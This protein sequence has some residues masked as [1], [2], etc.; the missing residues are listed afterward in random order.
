MFDR[1]TNRFVTSAFL[2]VA[3][4]SSL[5]AQSLPASSDTDNPA[6]EAQVINPDPKPLQLP[7]RDVYFQKG[8]AHQ[9][10]ADQKPLWTSPAHIKAS[11]AKWLVP[12]AAGTAFLFTQDTKVSQ[13]FANNPSL[14]N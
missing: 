6:E 10:I 9:L 1:F 8:F 14:Q 12:L 4:T 13:H 5:S 11:D 3:F 2:L 7:S